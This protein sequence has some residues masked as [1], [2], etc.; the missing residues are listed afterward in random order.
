MRRC[1]V[2]YCWRSDRVV[3]DGKLFFAK[4]YGYTGE[5]DPPVVAD[6]TC[7]ASLSQTSHSYSSDAVVRAGTAWTGYLLTNTSTFELKTLTWTSQSCP[8]NDSYRRYHYPAARTYS[9]TQ[10]E[11]LGDYLADHMPPIVHPP[12]NYTAIPATALLYWAICWNGFPIPLRP[13]HWQNIFQP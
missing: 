12:L 7:F 13:I 5:K 10:M 3:K 8:V 2:S 6:K 11:P 1:Q 9:S 4:G